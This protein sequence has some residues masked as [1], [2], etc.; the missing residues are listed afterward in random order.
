MH[1]TCKRLKVYIYIYIHSATILVIRLSE[2]YIKYCLRIRPLVW[3]GYHLEHMTLTSR[4]KVKQTKSG[5][6]LARV[7]EKDEQRTQC[8]Q[9]SCQPPIHPCGPRRHVNSHSGMNVHGLNCQRSAGSARGVV[10]CGC[11]GIPPRTALNS[12]LPKFRRRCL[13]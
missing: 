2:D 10:V 1:E 13:D 11:Q 9:A 8:K 5:R 7:Q 4:L 3:C 12:A 6:C